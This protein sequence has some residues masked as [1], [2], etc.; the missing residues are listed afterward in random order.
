MASIDYYVSDKY[1]LSF[2]FS[3]MGC[4]SGDGLVDSCNG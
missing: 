2:G 1:V 3:I 4:T